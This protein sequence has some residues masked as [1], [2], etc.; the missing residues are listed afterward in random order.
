MRR[1]RL[2][3]NLFSIFNAMRYALCALL[4]FFTALLAFIFLGCAQETSPVVPETEHP[5]EISTPS[6]EGLDG[7]I[8]ADMTDLIY[9]SGFG[10]IHSLIVLK[11]DKLVYE[12]YFNGYSQQDLH[13]VY[14]VTKSV[15]SALVGQAIGR[16]EIGDLDIAAADFFSEYERIIAT[17]TLKSQITLEH[18]LTMTAGFTWDEATYSYENPLNDVNRLS[19]SSDWMRFIWELPMEIIPGNGFR[20]NTGCT[21]LI[22]GI[23]NNSI[24]RAVDDYARIYLFGP[25]NI[26]TWDWENGPNNITNTVKQSI[27]K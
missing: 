7:Q 20:Y 14:S 3:R 6:A 9:A 21:V 23:L 17:D 19:V 1:D 13:P 10:Q 15:T 12:D 4:I 27:N 18:L 16:A 24:G 2:T 5:W 11:N 26:K 22:S 25:L 8:L